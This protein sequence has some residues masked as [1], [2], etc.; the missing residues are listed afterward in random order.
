MWCKLVIENMKSENDIMYI[1][2]PNNVIDD[3]NKLK[4]YLSEITN[5]LKCQDINIFVNN[6]PKVLMEENYGC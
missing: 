6:E 4:K 1:D 5:N 3:D 2:V